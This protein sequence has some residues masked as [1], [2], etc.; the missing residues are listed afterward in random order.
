MATSNTLVCI[1]CYNSEDTIEDLVESLLAY[2]DA[3]I[4]LVD[5]GSKVP[6]DS[7][8]PDRFANQM[9]RIQIV[10]PA[11][12]VY[13]GGGKNLG[14]WKAIEEGYEYLILMDSDLALP[15]RFVSG[16]RH[17]LQQH[18]TE[19]LVAPS[20]NPAGNRWQYADTMINF[21]TYLPSPGGKM[22][23]KNCLAGYAFALNMELY[24]QNPVYHRGRYGGE[25][26][27]FFHDVME[28]FKL[29]Y[30]PM[31]N[32][33]YVRHLPPRATRMDAKRA[34][35]RYGK[36]F[37]SHNDGSRERLFSSYPWMHFLTPRFMLMVS[38]LIRR[39]RYSDL[40]FVPLCWYLDICRA[41]R[42][43]QLHRDGYADPDKG[44]AIDTAEFQSKGVDPIKV[45]G[46]KSSQ[47]A[48]N[49]S[50]T[51]V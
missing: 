7:F 18:P 4:M 22:S 46:K 27:L 24:R 19:V 20:I 25:D 47:R 34:Q 29:D 41:N 51:G 35:Q 39:C 1:P 8:L 10:R 21:S 17:Y 38:R 50:S 2:S 15:H 42:I 33:I 30:L 6:L 12:K 45:G 43:V 31:L 3:D 48:V 16:L 28:Q 40:W 14:I 23:P 44:T 9:D 49:A 13:S 37:F 5:D 36:A 32:D 11:Q 26:V